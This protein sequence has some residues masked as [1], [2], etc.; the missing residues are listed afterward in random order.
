MR[1]IKT[2]PTDRET[3][4]NGFIA[5][6]VVDGE[7]DGIEWLGAPGNNRTRLCL[8]SNNY[9]KFPATHWMPLPEV[10]EE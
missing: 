3:L 8:N 7:I 9:S 6:S 5:F 2:A 4:M 1:P 10:T